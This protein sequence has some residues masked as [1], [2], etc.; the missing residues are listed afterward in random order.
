MSPASR[1]SG[2]V[3]AEHEEASA[4]DRQTL[5]FLVWLSGLAPQEE[6]NSSSEQRQAPLFPKVVG[7]FRLDGLL[8]RGAYGAVFR[9]FDFDADREVALKIAW[10][11]VLFSDAASR[12]FIDEP[13][14]VAELSHRGIIKV[15][16]YGWLDAICYISLELIEGP[17]L[18][19]WTSGENRQGIEA[20]IQIMEHVARAVHYAHEQGIVHRDLKPSNVLLRPLSKGGAFEPVVTDFGLARRPEASALS[21]ATLTGLVLGTDFYMSPEQAR[22]ICEVGPASDIFSIGTI[23]Y[24]LVTGRCPFAGNTSDEV[25]RQIQYEEVP[26]FRISQGRKY[27]ALATIVY[28]CL[29]KRPCDRYTTAKELADDLSRLLSGKSIQARRAGLFARGGKYARRKPAVVV[30]AAIAASALLF[31]GGIIGL[32]M[33]DRVSTGEQIALAEAAATKANE[34]ERKHQ[35]VWT[36][37]HAADAIRRGDA[38]HAASQLDRY[39]SSTHESVRDRIEWQYLS[40]QSKRAT[41]SWD[42]HAGQVNRLRFSPVGKWLA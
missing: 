18:E 27:N 22:G 5:G 23:L 29:E 16:G 33:F 13:K 25:R 30:A 3:C 39:A 38:T 41:R 12:R 2:R 36:I 31:V 15:L 28:K 42:A 8:G 35:Y 21:V 6:T 7:Q 20:T 14:I 34:S 1:D 40:E 17:T 10:P 37:Q 11:A 24:E 19:Q 9:A 32:W 4:R 26:A